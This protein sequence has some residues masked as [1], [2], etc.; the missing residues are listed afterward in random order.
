MLLRQLRTAMA[1]A[2]LLL[3]PS[4]FITP[5]TLGNPCVVDEDCGGDLVC[6]ESL[7][8]VGA[9]TS[10]T[11]SG[12][13][14]QDEGDAE[15]GSPAAVGSMRVIHAA[16]DAGAVDIYLAGAAEPLLEGLN[17]ADASGWLSLDVGTYTFEIRP[18]GSELLGDALYV[19]P[20]FVLDE[21]DQLSAI[22]AGVLDGGE[23]DSLRIVTVNE[24]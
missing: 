6:E 9:S 19:S 4:C 8:V 17:Y 16:P 2:S 14:T 5:D 23:D 7:C 13:D 15:T 18:A 21:G 3:F 10:E 11:S 20:E 24:Q 22:A 12:S 1:G